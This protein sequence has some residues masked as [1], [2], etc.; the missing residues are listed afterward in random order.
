[1]ANENNNINELVAADDDDDPTVELELSI[2]RQRL[3]ESD[4]RNFH[5]K[6]DNE[7]NSISDA[8]LTELTAD[9]RSRQETID[10]LRFDL[11]QL[12]AKWQ[13]LETEIDAR[14]G[15]ADDLNSE[16]VAAQESILRKDRLIKKRDQNVK[17]LKAEIRQ[18]DEEQRNLSNRCDD[19]QVT[20][21][22]I[23]PPAS[24]ST[25]VTSSNQELSKSELH[26]RLERSDEY[27]DSMRRQLQ[28]LMEVHSSTERELDHLSSTLETATRQSLDLTD[29]RTK[30]TA[31]IGELKEQLESIQNRHDEE[32]RILRFELTTAQDTADDSD[33]LNSQL[34]SD[35]INA[36]EFKIELERILNEAEEQS[37]SRIKKLQKDHNKLERRYKTLE[38]KLSAKSE[39][40][41]MLLAELATKPEQVESVSEIEDVFQ[42]IDERISEGNSKRDTK[43]PRNSGECVSRVLVG[44]VDDQVLQFPLFKDRLTIGRTKDNDIQLDAAYISRRHAVIQTDDTSVRI[45]DWGSKNGIRVNAERIDEHFLSHGDVITIGNARFRYEEHMKNNS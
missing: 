20:I 32:L 28:D 9:L 7:S 36:R 8:T 12:H 39:A 23:T 15:Q 11:Q 44:T 1:M 17:S 29:I 4:A 6:D 43:D 45:S 22:N 35:L 25:P 37:E 14:A 5:A 2:I 26:V 10:R 19:L 18:S 27:A 42:D 13:G 16:L 24:K 41:A 30:L 40:I 33:G 31:Q 34:T 21:D 3:P 38:Q